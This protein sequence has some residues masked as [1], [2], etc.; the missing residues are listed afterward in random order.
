MVAA[1]S[2]SYPLCMTVSTVLYRPI[3]IC[4]FYRNEK[5]IKLQM[6]DTAGLEKYRPIVEAYF[7]GAEGF[8]LMYDVT[9][10]ESFNAVTSW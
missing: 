2:E 4:G 7:R 1:S 10:R 9:N 5:K 8:L 6:W 3:L